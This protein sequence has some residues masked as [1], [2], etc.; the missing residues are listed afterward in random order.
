MAD[1]YTDADGEWTRMGGGF[2]LT[3]PSQAFLDARQAELDKQAVLDAE[4]AALALEAETTAALLLAESNKRIDD[5]V[6]AV[7]AE[8]NMAQATKDAINA[9]LA[10]YKAG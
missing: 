9:V 2:A 10:A 8:P 6:A 1:T 3:T 7:T 5:A 4:A